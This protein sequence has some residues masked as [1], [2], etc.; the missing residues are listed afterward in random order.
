MILLQMNGE[1]NSRI[2][3][4]DRLKFICNTPI[5]TQNEIRKE[6]RKLDT[7]K[8]VNGLKSKNQHLCE[9][10]IALY[11]EVLHL[12]AS[13]EYSLDSMSVHKDEGK[14][15][16]KGHSSKILFLNPD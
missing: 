3:W 9:F 15:L 2:I 5:P 8:Y 12:A 1:T 11:R 13:E 4:S 14:K 10:G 6:L 16:A 7:K